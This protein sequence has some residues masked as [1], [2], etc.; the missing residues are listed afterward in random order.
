MTRGTLI[1]IA[2]IMHS[3]LTVIFSSASA[4][5][6]YVAVNGSGDVPTIQA[7]IDTAAVGDT[8]LVGPGHYT[9]TNQ[10][11]GDHRG[12]IRFLRENNGFVFRSEAGADATVLDA[13][14]QCRTLYLQGMN[15]LTI[16]GFTVTHGDAPDFG[17]RFG[18]GLFTHI[19]NDVVRD[20]IFTGNRAEV[21]AGLNCAGGGS[22]MLVE[23]CIFTGNFSSSIGGGVGFT[24]TFTLSSTLS[25]CTITSNEAANEGGGVI[26]YGNIITIEDCIIAGNHAGVAGGGIGGVNV[27]MP[28]VIERCTIAEN[29]APTGAGVNFRSSSA[30]HLD[31]CIIAYNNGRGLDSDSGNTIYAGCN[32]IFGNTGGNGLA[33]GVVNKGGNIFIDAQFC[34]AKGSG[35]YYLQSDS[36]C[37]AENH[38]Q[39]QYQCGRIGALSAGC[40]SI[41]TRELSWGGI[42]LLM[43]K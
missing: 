37:L 35:N 10:G 25:G 15:G 42:K 11:T 22:S 4:R 13:Q 3:I 28:S 18:G 2:A 43:K 23:D 33:L 31:N 32:D 40:G 20:C 30:L 1:F 6:W 27:V 5:T 36:P 14:Y 17:D 19:S 9:W 12:F 8:V 34:G 26:V 39:P 41:G 38:P 24:G 16:E 29:I 7:A 21:G